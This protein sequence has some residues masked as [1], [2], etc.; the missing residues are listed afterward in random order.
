MGWLLR[1]TRRPALALAWLSR[2]RLPK[3]TLP[4]EPGWLAWQL[5]RWLVW[6]PVRW[7]AWR[8][9][10]SSLQV[11]LRVLQQVLQQLVSQQLVW[12]QLAWQR[13]AW[14]RV[15]LQLVLRLV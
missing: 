15:L 1:S 7:L 4:P 11:W 3:Q 14:L 10:A 12:R 13:L 8:Q 9:P 6:Q 2:W 5:V